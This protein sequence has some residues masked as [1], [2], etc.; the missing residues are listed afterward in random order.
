MK[1]SHIYCIIVLSYHTIYPENIAQFLIFYHILSDGLCLLLKISGVEVAPCLLP[2]ISGVE[3]TPSSVTSVESSEQFWRICE[4]CCNH[5]CAT[6]ISFGQFYSRT[7]VTR[8]LKGNEKQFELARNSNYW[9]K[10]QYD[11]DQGKK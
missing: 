3:V 9:D 1:K 10:F 2:K 5:R 6:E 11:L 8:T 4:C 7:Q